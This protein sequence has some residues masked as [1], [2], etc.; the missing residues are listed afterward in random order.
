MY[1]Y[2]TNQNLNGFWCDYIIP[3]HNTLNY[4]HITLSTFFNDTFFRF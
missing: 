1:I 2:G 3:A 4:L